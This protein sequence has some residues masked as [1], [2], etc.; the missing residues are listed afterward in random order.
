MSE[1]IACARKVRVWANPQDT[2]KY[3]RAKSAKL[4]TT[5]A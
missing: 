3:L 4:Y 1:A 5:A 2:G